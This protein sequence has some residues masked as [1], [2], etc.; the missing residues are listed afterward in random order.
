[1]QFDEQ[2]AYNLSRELSR[3]LGDGLT[4]SLSRAHMPEVVYTREYKATSAK[5][6]EQER[7]LGALLDGNDPDDVRHSH[8]CHEMIQMA[9]GKPSML[10]SAARMSPAQMSPAI[11]RM[12]F[13]DLPV[14]T[15]ADVKTL[16]DTLTAALETKR[17]C[18][19]NPAYGIGLNAATAKLE[20]ACDDLR[21]ALR[22][23]KAYG[24]GDI[25]PPADAPQTLL[26]I[27][28]DMANGKP[29]KR[30]LAAV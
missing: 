26:T 16:V 8:F 18:T 5:A 19:L 9:N 2:R 4:L 1:M 7:R 10:L 30:P 24:R 25:A 13:K 20:R 17:R 22:T 12:G 29:P 3:P 23:R 21:A 15:D 11:T 28:T 6:A 14:P 27:M